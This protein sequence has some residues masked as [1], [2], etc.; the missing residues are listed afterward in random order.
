MTAVDLRVRRGPRPAATPDAPHRQLDQQ[1]LD[2]E[3]VRRLGER[4][5]AVAPGAHEEPSGI[6]VPGARALVL[7]AD[8]PTGPPEAF[9][10]GREFAH[11]HPAPDH[12]L[13]MTLPL[14]LARRAVQQRWAEPHVAVVAGLL[15]PTFVM[16][17]APRDER[18]LHVVLAL[19]AA[20]HRFATGGGPRDGG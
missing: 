14:E 11:V 15:P 10:V 1:P 8:T 17:Y 9:L 5:F 19:L 7:D 4:M 18:E 2:P 16:V 6:S 13:H 3:I 20:S 12:S